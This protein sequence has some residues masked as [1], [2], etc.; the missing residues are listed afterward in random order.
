M[1]KKE[2]PRSPGSRPSL[3]GSRR[4]VTRKQGGKSTARK[5][6]GSWDDEGNR[7][8]S[9]GQGTGS[10]LIGIAQKSSL[11]EINYKEIIKHAA[12]GF[13]PKGA[14]RRHLE[15]KEIRN[16]PLHGPPGTRP[17]LCKP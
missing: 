7:D 9:K 6:L 8:R 13:C 5:T 14:F 2:S 12:K 16:A 4:V 11:G 10:V 17:E 1:A 3:R 15:E